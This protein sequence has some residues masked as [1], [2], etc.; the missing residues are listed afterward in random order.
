MRQVQSAAAPSEE[1]RR[2]NQPTNQ[3][4]S[5]SQSCYFA[6]I[7]YSVLFLDFV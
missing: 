2:I 3:S 1:D 6:F 4:H 7:V 5:V